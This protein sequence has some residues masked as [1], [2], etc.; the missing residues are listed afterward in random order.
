MM[1]GLT[2]NTTNIRITQL[3]FN[4]TITRMDYSIVLRYRYHEVKRSFEYGSIVRPV[5]LN[6]CDSL[7]DQVHRLMD[8][9][10][11]TPTPPR[12]FKSW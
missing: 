3:R 10:W 11:L 9:G 8:R 5:N 2:D 1:D 4:R 6:T 12:L 7:C